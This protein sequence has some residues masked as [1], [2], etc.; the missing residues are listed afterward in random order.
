VM[1]KRDIV[2]W[3]DPIESE[4]EKFQEVLVEGVGLK[5]V[6]IADRETP[7]PTILVP[8]AGVLNPYVF[9]CA[10]WNL[11]VEIGLA[12]GIDIDR[13]VRAR[14]IGNAFIG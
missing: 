12:S 11:L 7:F 6:A 10:G 14:K 13:P 2:F 1:D 9:L 5:V 3:I 4:M 8:S